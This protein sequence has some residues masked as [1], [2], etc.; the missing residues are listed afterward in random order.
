MF[1]SVA[2]LSILPETLILILGVI[3]LIIEPF[4]KE[5]RR[6]NLGWLTAGGLLV[7]LV[8]V[9]WWVAPAIRR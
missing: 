3:L 2:F 8:S 7:I 6:R 4:L 5:E 1:T 9:F